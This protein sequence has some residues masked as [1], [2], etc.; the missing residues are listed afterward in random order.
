M[1]QGDVCNSLQQGMD[2]SVMKDEG[3]CGYI[4]LQV[5]VGVMFGELLFLLFFCYILSHRLG[6]TFNSFTPRN[7]FESGRIFI[8]I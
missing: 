3:Q 6:Q 1:E 2:G 8:Y 7:P 4:S 5:E